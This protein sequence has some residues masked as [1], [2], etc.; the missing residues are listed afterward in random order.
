[1][2]DHIQTEMRETLV[3]RAT[4]AGWA[5]FYN[6]IPCVAEV[7]EFAQAVKEAMPNVKFLPI[8]TDYVS[9]AV[10]DDAGVYQT[11]KNVRVCSE[12]AVYLDDYPLDLGRINF[13][14][15]GARKKDTYTYGI[16]SRKIAN[17]KY[18]CHRDQHHMVTA[19]DLK[20]A[21]KKVS[22]YFIPFSTKELAQ[23]FYEPLKNDVAK[24][25][26]TLEREM[27][28]KADPIVH[29][30][31]ELLQE[32][33]W[34]KQ[35]GVEFSS[36]KFRDIAENVEDI[37]T[38]YEAEQN[39]SIGAIFVRF[40]EIGGEMY[41]ST[42]GAIE[43]KKHH[44]QLQGTEEW[45]IEGKPVEEMPEDIKGAVAV[46]SILNNGQYVASVG[47]KVDAKHFWIERG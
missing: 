9:Y 24:L 14:D 18:A 16:Y 10:N 3:K 17:A 13:R 34:L 6:G 25:G 19:T 35:R 32:I 41:F 1:M 45:K 22:Q 36:P 20:K 23:A 47:V 37:I 12:F 4:E 29:N 46:L 8:D 43:I 40:Y 39:R 11:T 5:T 30:H 21:M 26:N 15:N 28:T 2:S 7:K 38:R 33:Y 42:Q 44:D 31:H 27:R